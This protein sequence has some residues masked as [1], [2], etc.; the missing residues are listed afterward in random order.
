MFII[1]VSIFQ[2]IIILIK[3][4]TIFHGLF[5]F[6]FKSLIRDL[7]EFLSSY[8]YSFLFII[9]FTIYRFIEKFF[10]SFEEGLISMF[11][12]SERVAHLP[13]AIIITAF[14]TILLPEFYSKNNVE[15]KN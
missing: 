2:I 15:E 9:T 13:T 5:I 11:Y 14:S 8:L 3:D 1:S 6:N 12:L 10:L 4:S 7:I